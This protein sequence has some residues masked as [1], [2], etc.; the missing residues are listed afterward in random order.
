[1]KKW[2][3]LLKDLNRPCLLRLEW[4]SLKWSVTLS[5]AVPHISVPALPSLRSGFVLSAQLEM[6][7]CSVSAL[8]D[9]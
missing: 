2:R 1:M 9:G 4:S 7:S 3:F 8:T 5:V 6:R